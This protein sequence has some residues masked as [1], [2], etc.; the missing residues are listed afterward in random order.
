MMEFHF[1]SGVKPNSL[2]TSGINGTIPNHAKKHIKKDIDVIQKVRMDTFLKFNKF[3]F[4][5][6]VGVELFIIKYFYTYKTK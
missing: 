3:K 4:V 6:L 1:W 2:T 5:D